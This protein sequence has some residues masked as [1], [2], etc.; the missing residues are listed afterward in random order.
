MPRKLTPNMLRKQRQEALIQEYIT[1]EEARLA[2]GYS[3]KKLLD[4]CLEMNV[5]HMKYV[6]KWHF[7]RADLLDAINGMKRDRDTL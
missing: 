2:T 4:W 5:R 7:H 1:M 3:A 6:N